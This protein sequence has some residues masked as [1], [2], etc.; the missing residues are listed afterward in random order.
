MTRE[1]PLR[2]A[3][4]DLRNAA[5]VDVVGAERREREK[6]NRRRFLWLIFGAV[7]SLWAAVERER[8]RNVK[9]QRCDSS[10]AYIIHD[11][12]GQSGL[13]TFFYLSVFH[14]EHAWPLSRA[15]LVMTGIFV[16]VPDVQSFWRFGYLML[17]IIFRFYFNVARD[18][19]YSRKKGFGSFK[20]WVNFKLWWKFLY[21]YNKSY[22]R[23]V[24]KPSIDF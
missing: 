20:L 14:E 15:L 18:K 22:K 4:G 6:K 12:P 13:L 2:G 17:S 19:W 23:I 16:W 21:I 10:V 11:L 3:H 5:V 9:A 8:G 1:Y 7:K 24:L